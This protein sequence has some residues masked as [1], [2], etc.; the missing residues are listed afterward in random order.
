M[1]SV[2]RQQNKITEVLKKLDLDEKE[3]AVF[4]F[5]LQKNAATASQIA[6]SCKHITRTSVYD[7]AKRLQK[8]GI[9]TSF[10]QNNKTYFQ[11]GN[12][13]HI[14][15]SLENKKREMTDTQNLLR[16][17]ADIFRQ[18]KSGS[19]Y[20]PSVRFFEGKNGIMAIHRELQ[21]ARK[22]TK[23]IVNIAAVSKEFPGIF[24][25]DTLKDFQTY[26]IMKKDLMIKNP[27]AEKYLKIAKIGEFHKVK[28]LPEGT[29]LQTDTLIWE[30]H[31]AII[32]YTENLSGVV[33]DNPTIADTFSV[34]FDL[35]WNSI[36]E[37]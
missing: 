16:E 30:G 33:I 18:I 15:D 14:I 12:V 35:I 3:T 9:I 5:L 34:W 13:E 8:I 37:K 7:I 21:N 2:T 25:E 20:T 24:Y 19:I 6:K 10:E 22:E 17:T 28:W 26:K 32:D 36:T 11:I 27:E 31:T 23:T 1:S 4:L 29:G